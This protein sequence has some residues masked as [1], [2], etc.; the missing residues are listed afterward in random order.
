MKEKEKYNAYR[1]AVTM[2]VEALLP[3][4]QDISEI[5]Y[6]YIENCGEMGNDDYLQDDGCGI[7]DYLDDKIED[8]HVFLREVKKEIELTDKNFT[9]FIKWI[10]FKIREIK[11]KDCGES[12]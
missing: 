12:S 5:I 10:S 8:F 3:A 6:G 1:A 9:D 11:Y 2:G 4:K 7:S